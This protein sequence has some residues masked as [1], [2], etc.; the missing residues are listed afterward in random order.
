MGGL[1]LARAAPLEGRRRR[2]GRRGDPQEDGGGGPQE[3]RGGPKLQGCPNLEE[4][5]L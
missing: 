5:V 2:P 4:V 3:S 1:F